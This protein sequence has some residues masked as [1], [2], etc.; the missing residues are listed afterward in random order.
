MRPPCEVVQRDFLRPVRAFVARSLKEEG[1][2][3][4]EI[5]SKMDLTQA[6]VS[7]YL[8][9]PATETKLAGEISRLTHTL[10]E[11][12]KTGETKA[13]LIVREICS[14]CMRSRLG[15]TL[16]EMHQDRVSSLKDVNCQVCSQLLGGSDDNLSDRAKV[17][18][19]ILES[20][21][22]IE[23]SETFEVIV[24]QVRANLVACNNKAETMKDVAGVPGRITII[25]G[26]ARALTSPQ[27]GASQHTAELLLFAKKTWPLICA[28]LCV[29]GTQEV[30]DIAKKTGFQVIS[31]KDPESTAS[32]IIESLKSIDQ[33]PGRRTSY[34]A[35]HIPGGFGVE[36]ILYLFGPS[37]KELSG[38]SVRI[39]DAIKS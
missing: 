14:T 7:K 13:D 35:I 6:A 8:S 33:L 15:S 29:S 18:G 16:C 34:P 26:R 25:D 32:R 9:Q 3:Q 1:F 36:P 31:M 20:L 2:S 11:M 4:T 10:T 28:C 17:I 37:A 27:F 39:S 22:I 19:D 12:I 23:Q 38:Q 5:A 21:R 30:V 24:P